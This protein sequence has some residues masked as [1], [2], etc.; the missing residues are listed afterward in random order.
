[1]ISLRFLRFLSVYLALLGMSVT[2]QASNIQ[3]Q[4]YKDRLFGYPDVLDSRD[5]G[6]FLT[7]DYSEERDID[8]R[9]QI[10]E[11][12]V[13]GNYVSTMPKRQ[14]RGVTLTLDDIQ[15]EAFEIGPQR[16]ARFAV[17]FVHGRGGDKRLGAKDWT[18]GG[19]FNRLKN[20]AVRNGGVY[21]A[22]SI[23]SF[24]AV[25]LDHLKTLISHIRHNM[26]DAPIVLACGSMGSILCWESGNDTR[27]IK[28]LA[29]SVILGGTVDKSFLNSLAH[30]GRTPVLLAHGSRD[31][32]YDWQA[33]HAL[34]QKIRN[35]GDQPY[36]I[37]FV[38]FQ[39]GTHGTPIRMVDWRDT[40]NWILAQ[41]D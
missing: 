23:P 4:P 33:Q 41:A 18:F 31:S 40:I 17:I 8:R 29:G 28:H 11:R 19:N 36:P 20:L 16:G 27:I 15:V 5:G 38:L 37:R 22:P 12:R 25:G 35:S 9:D 26:P 10:P 2:A 14:Q 6:A 32:V 39:D 13:K 3:L 1:M 7:I 24:D 21:Y 30:R 34:Y